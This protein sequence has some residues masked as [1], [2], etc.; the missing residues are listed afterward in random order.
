MTAYQRAAGEAITRF[1]GEVVRYVGDGI[2]AFFGYPIAHDNDGER[3]V[4]AGLAILDAI[5]PLNERPAPARLAVRIGINSGQV[6]VSAGAGGGQAV[7]AF[8]DAA[9]IAARVETGADPD[10]VMISD[11]TQRLVAGLFIVEDRG[12]QALKGIERPVRLYRVIRPSGARGRFEAASGGG[13]T[14][15]VRRSRRRAALVAESMGTRAGGRRAGCHDYRRGGHR[16]IALGA[17][18]SRTDRRDAAHLA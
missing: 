5:K 4:R 10:T 8:G 13:W 16:K 7:D 3:A 14:D 18:L 11:A 1:E 15:D 6:V 9:N 17:A 12:A 2:L